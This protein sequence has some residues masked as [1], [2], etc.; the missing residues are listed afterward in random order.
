MK[1]L[2]L[3]VILCLIIS[4]IVAC[5]EEEEVSNIPINNNSS[6]INSMPDTNSTIDEMQSQ[7][8]DLQSQLSA[9]Q[10]SVTSTSSF[11]IKN[12]TTLLFNGEEY[13]SMDDERLS[14]YALDTIEEMYGDKRVFVSSKYYF[15]ENDKIVYTLSWTKK[16]EEHPQKSILKTMKMQ[17]YPLLYINMDT[18]QEVIII[19]HSETHK[20]YFNLNDMME[21]GL[22]G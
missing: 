14:K 11:T 20:R 22:I 5:G 6:Q 12:E 19:Y 13:I 9:L 1:K 4:L 7:I 2:S 18:C 21:T 17:D 3:I 16:V 10:N 8:A 15:K